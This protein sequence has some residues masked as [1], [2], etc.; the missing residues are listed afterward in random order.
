MPITPA[1]LEEIKA[2]VE[3]AWMNLVN[4]QHRIHQPKR[5]PKPNHKRE[6]QK[7]RWRAMWQR[8]LRTNAFAK[9]IRQAAARGDVGFFTLL[10]H[11]VS[12]RFLDL[13]I[14][15]PDRLDSFLV[16][17]W[18]ERRDGLPELFY[19]TPSDLTA[20]CIQHLKDD[21][22]EQEQ[23][24]KARQRLGLKAFKREKLHP[25]YGANGIFF[26]EPDN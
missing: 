1:E 6:L 4:K 23:V 21:S 13:P 12:G 17:H 16:S 15:L 26:P 22:L 9:V 20:V 18:A 10:G 24:V 25:R 19:L 5:R 7:Q 11:Q 8:K 14:Y 2:S 3:R